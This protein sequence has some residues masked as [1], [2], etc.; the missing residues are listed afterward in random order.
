[1]SYNNLLEG[2]WYNRFIIINKAAEGEA[3][4]FEREREL[5]LLRKRRRNEV[6]S[7]SGLQHEFEQH[8]RNNP[9]QYKPE[10]SL[11]QTNK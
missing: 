8:V 4:I 2:S 10:R 6:L 3:L 7:S 11:F 5:A 9:T 1:M